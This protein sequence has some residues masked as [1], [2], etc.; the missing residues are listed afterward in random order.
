[1]LKTKICFL[2]FLEIFSAAQIQ[3][4]IFLNFWKL[5]EFFGLKFCRTDSAFGIFGKFENFQRFC[6]T[7]RLKNTK[8]S[9]NFPTQILP[10]RLL[11]APRRPP[12]HEGDVRSDGHESGGEDVLEV[13]L[14]N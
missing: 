7:P 6:R 5:F 10:R 12:S 14:G 13:G 4:I 3:Q 8:F 9:I 2:G 1:M 11:P